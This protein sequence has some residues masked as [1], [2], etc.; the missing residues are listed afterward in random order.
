MLP[1]FKKKLIITDK[2]VLCINIVATLFLLMSYLAPY[3]NPAKFGLIAVLGFAY[4]ILVPVNMIFIIYWLIRPIKLYSLLS[5]VSVI[6]GFSYIICYC[7]MHFKSS[8][9][10]QK[11]MGVIRIMQFN[12]R[13]FGIFDDNGKAVQKGIYNFLRNTNPDII[14]ME[15]FYSVIYNN[16]DVTDSI[17][18]VMQ[19]KYKY[20]QPFKI[21]PTDSTGNAIF[22][23]Y[24]IIHSGAV[25]FNNGDF[26]RAIYV[27]VKIQGKIV[28]V[29]SV[30]LAAVQ[31]QDEEKAKFLEGRISINRTLFIEN[32]L[33]SAFKKRSQQ[34]DVIKQH[35][36]KCPYPVIITGDFNDTPISYSV[37][38]I[39]RGLQNAFKAKGSGFLKTYYSNY[40]LQIDF[41]FTGKS[42]DILNYFTADNKLSDHKP[43]ISDVL[44][45]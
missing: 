22:S 43:V 31:I 34:A 4:P 41:I 11:P 10:Q 6:I 45:K 42:F 28:R 18:R 19:S 21:T 1:I 2:I 8:L 12:V 13:A 30:H 24:P 32:K 44:L 35:I 36:N 25:L 33:I 23:K 15:E 5:L 14:S 29:Y 37:N 20:F 17:R 39:G 3:A 27:D 38:T 40:P 16:G 7:G 26:T 9:G